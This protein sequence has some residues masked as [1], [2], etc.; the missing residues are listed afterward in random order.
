MVEVSAGRNDSKLG[1]SSFF[2][3]GRKSTS[4]MY[5]NTDNLEP[6]V[7]DLYGNEFYD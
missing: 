4:R 5:R 1:G 3:S 6:I 2:N 7:E